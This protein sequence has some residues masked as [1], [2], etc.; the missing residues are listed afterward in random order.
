MV[1]RKEKGFT[2][3]ELLV[4]IAII[5]LLLS[6][7]VPTLSRAREQSRRV[8]CRSNVNQIGLA[9]LMYAQKN[10]SQLPLR[11]AGLWLQDASYYLTDL[12][13]SAGGDKYT[14]Y[15]PSQKSKDPDNPSVWRFEEVGGTPDGKEPTDIQDRKASYRVTGYHWLQDDDVPR[16]WKVWGGGDP[17]FQKKWPRRTTDSRKTTSQTLIADVVISVGTNRRRFT[18]IPAGLADTEGILDSTNH[19]RS[20]TKPEGANMY[21]LDGHTEWQQFE[22]MLLNF[23]VRYNNQTRVDHWW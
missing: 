20:S 7:L 13:I 19:A 17:M 2:L 8:V 10:D 15:C 22:G 14:F 18:D 3:V 23:Y 16:T 5:A 4:V 1:V 11:T 9:M 21:F 12:V 6:I